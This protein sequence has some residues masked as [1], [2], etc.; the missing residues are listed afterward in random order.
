M[1]TIYLLILLNLLH[2]Q[3]KYLIFNFIRLI[4][5]NIQI[6][7]LL[8]LAKLIN[9]IFMRLVILNQISLPN[10]INKI[11]LCFIK[12]LKKQIRGLILILFNLHT[13]NIAQEITPIIPQTTLLSRLFY[14]LKIHILSGLSSLQI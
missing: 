10:P 3:S 13:H 1:Q 11:I 4:H 12:L 2:I 9:I 7:Q 5:Y 6:L 14:F 8:L